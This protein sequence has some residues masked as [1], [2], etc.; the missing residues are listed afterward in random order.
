LNRDMCK[1]ESLQKDESRWQ[2]TDSSKAYR[3]TSAIK[4]HKLVKTEL[5]PWLH[6]R[7]KPFRFHA[8]SS[9]SAELRSHRS[10]PHAY[11]YQARQ[12]DQ[13]EPITVRIIGS[14][15]MYVTQPASSQPYFS[16]L[17]L[18]SKKFA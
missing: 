5:L 4:F 14:V 9:W 3:N 11:I 17:R 2:S 18:Q 1:F 15:C 16:S 12:S 7:I 8:E 13:V 10:E 6:V